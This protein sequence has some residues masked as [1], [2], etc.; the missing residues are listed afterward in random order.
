MFYQNRMRM[1]YGMKRK[2][3]FAKELIELEL[4]EVA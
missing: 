1:E 4:M 3:H 2:L